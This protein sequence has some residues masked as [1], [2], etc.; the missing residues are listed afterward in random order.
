MSYI[1]ECPHCQKRLRA[2]KANLNN[3][4]KCPACKNR[5]T[6]KAKSNTSED[7]PE[8]DVVHPPPVP[9]QSIMKDQAT[10]APGSFIDHN[11]EDL[12]STNSV[13]GTD[14]S[15]RNSESEQI[16]TVKQRYSIPERKIRTYHQVLFPPVSDCLLD[17]LVIQY[18]KRLFVY[19]QVLD[20]CHDCP[21]VIPEEISTGIVRI[22]EGSIKGH[23]VF[24]S[25][26]QYATNKAASCGR[27]S[28]IAYNV[29]G[30]L[31]RLTNGNEISPEIFE[32]DG[33]FSHEHEHEMM[34]TELIEEYRAI[35]SNVEDRVS[36]LHDFKKV[37]PSLYESYE[38]M[39]NELA[40]RDT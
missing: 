1:I 14:P 8:K 15:L 12:N 28:S 40:G 38:R 9:K 29:T 16:E 21:R 30:T 33:I 10:K 26:I 17:P 39:L 25:R 23:E 19:F 2:T 18:I 11:E 32:L 31:L 20:D 7:R 13:A 37:F 22:A 3:R 5:F 4:A 35:L 24:Q 36:V 6:V 34:S 27:I